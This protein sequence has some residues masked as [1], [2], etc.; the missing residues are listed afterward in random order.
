MA[1]NEPK[2][3][4][5]A[6]A[7]VDPPTAL[8]SDKV[9]PVVATGMNDYT[10][11][12]AVL[13]TEPTRFAFERSNTRAAT[14]TVGKRKKP[15]REEKQGKLADL[16]PGMIS[17]HNIYELTET[18]DEFL[19]DPDFEI[20]PQEESV[21]FQVKYADGGGEQICGGSADEVRA[22]RLEFWGD[23]EIV[24]VEEIKP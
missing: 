19:L 6:K 9:A 14:L 2:V 18:D 20:V 8:A 1:E 4:T 12:D 23:R 17:P 24:S 15:L 22:A 13:L 21:K 10:A 3:E 16:V 5:K 7:P 11:P